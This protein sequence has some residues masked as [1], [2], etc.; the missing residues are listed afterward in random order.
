[1]A[2]SPMMVQYNEIKAQ[3][4]DCI[5]MMRIGDFYEMFF[6][7]AKVASRE[8]EL[9]LTGKDCGLPERAPMCGVPHHALDQY[10]AKL[11]AKGYRAAIVDQLEDP[12]TAKGLVKRGVTRIVTPG[13]VFEGGFL[14]E[15]ENNYICCICDGIDGYGVT[16]ADVSTGE[17]FATELLGDRAEDRLISEMASY[18]PRELV[19]APTLDEAF[20]K[21][22]SERY[23]ALLTPLDAS[24]FE[25]ARAEGSYRSLFGE[26][27]ADRPYAVTAVGALLTLLER[28]QRTDLHYMKTP[29]F[30]EAESYLGIDSFSRRNLELCETLRSGERKGSLLWAIDR[31][32]T[33]AG[34]R[35]LRK[36]ME[37]PLLNSVAIRARQA[38]VQELFD[39]SILRDEL[40]SLLRSTVDVERLTTKL[41]YGT[42]NARDLKALERTLKQVPALQKQIEGCKAPRLLDLCGRMDALEE[43]SKAI[44]E[45]I[46]EEPAL[47]VKDGGIIKPGC[48]AAVDELRSM[49]ED[50]KS[51]ITKIEETERERTGIR[52][53]K[54]GYNR[55]FGYYIEVSR[56]F[57]GQVPEDYIRRQTLT[58]GERFVTPE[59]K[60][61]E[62]R[63]LGAKDRDCALEYELFC[64]L[65]EFVL[66][67][68]VKLQETAVAIAELD[69]L[70]SFAEIAREQNYVCPEVDGSDCIEIKGGR[71]PVVERFLEG[72]YFVPNDC[73]LDKQNRLLLIT[74]PNMAGKS[75][76]MRQ[77]ALIT[78]LAQMGSFVPATEA[79][80][81]I[82]DRIFTR[83][84]ASDD[85]ASGN[86]T[87]MLEMN[88][89]A[90]ILKNATPR[91]L[92]IYDEIGRGT[93]TYDGMSIARAVAEHTCKKIGAK[94]LF[95]THYHELTDLEGALPG[96]VNYHIAAKKRGND[97]MFLRKIV[98][99][100]ADD[101]YGIEVAALAGVPSAVVNR[102]KQVLAELLEAGVAPMPKSDNITESDN[103]TFGDLSA[104]AIAD[105]LRETDLNL[106]TP[107]EAM[108]LLFELKKLL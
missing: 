69:V 54:V 35:L 64:S 78:V 86:S 103:V 43:V 91:S 59:L 104:N 100:A 57:L 21:R 56:S 107:Y 14:R 37:R 102:A 33:A 105:K 99:G 63:V 106:L 46:S 34:A 75:T 32:R 97:I 108:T 41:V 76:Y 30:Y 13:T 5:V 82:V 15:G 38:A 94:T 74:G 24:A 20:A 1:M 2:L 58:T 72:S 89:V 53:L 44:Y 49:M 80:V 29:V 85:L 25:Q 77:V 9:V 50:G 52:S 95:A 47:T 36:W 23:R 8:L 98:R 87:F 10:L 90:E 73:A 18:A 62:A 81:G 65:R 6:E 31:T 84:G 11:V 4:P 45:T 93:S 88:E 26:P 92:I 16:F 51:W 67:S 61:M 27:A 39:D 12:S 83:I 48:N 55:V 28:T 66:E 79:R 19:H 7:D 71:H 68:L 70:C 3:N 17:V 101:S 40:M 42:A 22:L 60:D 96:V